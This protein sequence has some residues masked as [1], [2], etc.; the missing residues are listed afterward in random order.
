MEEA[1]AGV[2]KADTV[3]KGVE[4]AVAV[5]KVVQECNAKGVG[6]VVPGSGGVSVMEGAVET[7]VVELVTEADTG[8][9]ILL[10]MTCPT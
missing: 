4:E 1:D 10:L 7:G 6:E 8:A 3:V 9:V 5:G 2:E